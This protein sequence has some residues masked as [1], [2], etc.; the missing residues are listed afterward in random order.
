MNHLPIL[1][2]LEAVR[3]PP[4]WRTDQAILSTYSADPT[5]LIALL[6]A[7]AGRDDD[8][9]HGSRVE[10]ARSLIDLRG[11]VTFLMQRGRLSAPR[12]TPYVLSLLDRFIR[13]VP[14]NEKET[15][16]LKGRSWHAKLA[17][18]RLVAIEGEDEHPPLWRLWI[19]SRNF[20]RDT[21][22]DIGLS[23]DSLESTAK[24]GRILPGIE[25]VAL[26]LAKY[27][28]E[29]DHWQS[30]ALELADLKWN[31]PAGLNLEK[32]ELMLPEDAHRNFPSSPTGV[33]KVIAVA[34]FLDGGTIS[35]FS[36]WT[37]K[38]RTLI[39][40]I[41]ELG[42]LS[43][44]SANPLE[45]F[46]LLVLPASTQDID[47]QSEE[48]DSQSDAFSEMQGLHA[49]LIWAEHTG[50]TTLWLGSPNLTQRAWNR[51]AE[52]FVEVAIQIRGGAK[53]ANSIYEGIDT[54]RKMARPVTLEELELEE[55]S[56]DDQEI[57]EVARQEV[58]AR[59]KGRQRRINSE[60]TI[61]ETFEIP[62]HPDEDGVVL[63]VSRMGGSLQE[64]PRGKTFLSLGKN[65]ITECSDLVSVR[66]SLRNKSIS[67]TQLVPFDPPLTKTRDD[68]A[69]L[70]KFVGTRGTLGWLSDVLDDSMN[71]NGGGRW[72]GERK[73]TNTDG[74]PLQSSIVDTPTVEKVLRA[75]LR[76]P[77]CLHTV[78]HILRS[79]KNSPE[80]IDDDVEAQ[81]QLKAFMRSWKTLRTGLI[82]RGHRVD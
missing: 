59:L 19:G 37:D 33:R 31:V 62:P 66:V 80:H 34:P 43:N 14:W 61:V 46:D 42:K 23:I 54:F 72:D 2:L 76:N 68:T 10:L 52:V 77:N 53:V 15:S 65:D 69:I 28:G 55:P 81:L 36:R 57:L 6:L 8:S 74:H 3:P 60:F 58:A 64:W 25:R 16:D 27:A 5:V 75:W 11:K 17:L 12:K 67:W 44:Q 70:I 71:S 7:L 48:D 9:G 78:D 18:V 73:K 13:E 82:S 63:S 30:L 26:R 32:V 45:G 47:P 29:L 41:S 56:E 22:W 51:N 1:P 20:T 49:K 50:G 35:S 38:S 24:R 21:S 4:G 79:V 40:T 39:S